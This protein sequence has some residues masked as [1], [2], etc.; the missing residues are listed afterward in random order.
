VC[1]LA[2]PSIAVASPNAPGSIAG[3]GRTSPPGSNSPATVEK[4]PSVRQRMLSVPRRL[5]YYLEQDRAIKAVALRIFL[6]VVQQASR[7]ASPA[8]VSDSR[9]G[10]VAFVR[11]FGALLNPHEHVHGMVIEGVFK[12][13]AS[14]TET[15]PCPRPEVARRSAGIGVGTAGYWHPARHYRRRSGFGGPAVVQTWNSR[16]H[17]RQLLAGC[18]PTPSR[19]H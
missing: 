2:L 16:S 8:A 13:D 3:C 10:A 18:R 7:R 9:I 4:T 5:R 15:L 12:A 1:L 11:R 19:T 6:S 14:G 17:H